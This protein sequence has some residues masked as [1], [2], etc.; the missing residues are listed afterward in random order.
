MST[1]ISWPVNHGCAALAWQGIPKRQ[2][3]LAAYIFTTAR[4]HRITPRRQAGIAGPPKRDTKPLH[5]HWDRFTSLGPALRKMTRRLF[6]GY[7][8]PPRLAT[9]H[10]G[11]IWPIWCLKERGIRTIR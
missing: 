4:C 8:S 1:G 2:R 3:W 7:G 11:W 10:H 6:V 5:E 9:R